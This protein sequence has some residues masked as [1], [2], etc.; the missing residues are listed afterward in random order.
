MRP[1]SQLHSTYIPLVVGAVILIVVLGPRPAHQR[2]IEH[3]GVRFLGAIALVAV[4]GAGAV[5]RRA[6]EV[7]AEADEV[8][9]LGLAARRVDFGAPARQ[10]VV[11]LGGGGVVVVDAVIEL[12]EWMLG[13]SHY[14]TYTQHKLTTST[15]ERVCTPNI[16]ASWPTRGSP[17]GLARTRPP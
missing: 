16:P 15:I 5:V 2:A 3:V 17:R 11:D 9:V 7:D 14:L 13:G 6:G 10:D 8:G 4:A 12:N 1:N